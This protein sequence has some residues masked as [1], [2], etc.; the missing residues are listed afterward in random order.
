MSEAKVIA[1][2]D[3]TRIIIN[4]G[5]ENTEEDNYIDEGTEIAI[6]CE[7]INIVDPDTKKPLG[8]YYPIIEKLK[9]TEVYDNF[10][11]ARK[12][13]KKKM[14]PFTAA[15]IP[16]MFREKEYSEFK[17]LNI[18]ENIS[19]RPPYKNYISIGDK[20]RFI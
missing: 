1:I 4:I 15:N 8:S 5:S 17:H 3:D 14:T 13:V 9:I 11:V 18:D 20:V 10:S 12:L 2:P 7:S 6:V 19:L 16:P